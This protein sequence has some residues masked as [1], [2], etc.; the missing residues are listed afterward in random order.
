M[1]RSLVKMALGPERS[2]LVRKGLLTVTL[3]ILLIPASA[4]EAAN[5]PCSGSKGGIAGCQGDAFLC[6]DGSVSGSKKSCSAYMGGAA[7]LLGASEA[8]MSPAV[9]EE[10][11]CRSGAYCTG[12]R[13][14]RYCRT[15][16]GPKS[17]LRK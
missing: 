11:S 9:S 6:S 8:Q 14:G 15:D 4:L 3:A 17:Y 13:G 10:C 12:P 7:G 16:S 1:S 5:S 2:P